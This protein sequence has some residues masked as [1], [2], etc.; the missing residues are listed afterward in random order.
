[1]HELEALLA[2]ISDWVW[3]PPLLSLLEDPR[4]ARAE[5]T[6]KELGWLSSIF[7]RL[8]INHPGLEASF[9]ATRLRPAR[10]AFALLTA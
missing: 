3:G 10:A 9:D 1:M 4:A 6:S 5:I 2:K 7:D 8:A